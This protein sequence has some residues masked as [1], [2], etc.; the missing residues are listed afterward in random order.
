MSG[1]LYLAA[2]CAVVWLCVWAAG[3]DGDNDE[4]LAPQTP[5]PRR[6]IWAPFDYIRVSAI[7]ST[8]DNVDAATSRTILDLGRPARRGSPPAPGGPATVGCVQNAEGGWRAKRN[9]QQHPRWRSG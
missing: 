6:G 1:L 5:H 8:P 7:T 3:D 4:V 2:L 9:T